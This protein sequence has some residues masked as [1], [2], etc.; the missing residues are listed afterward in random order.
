MGPFNLPVVPQ[1]APV[2]MLAVDKQILVT[3]EGGIP[4][5]NEASDRSSILPGA[6]KPRSVLGPHPYPRHSICCH[7]T[8]HASSWT[9]VS[10]LSSSP[11]LSP[12][13]VLSFFLLRACV[14]VRSLGPWLTLKGVGGAVARLPARA[15]AS[16]TGGTGRAYVG[17][18]LVG[19]SWHGGPRTRPWYQQ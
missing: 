2:Q 11:L 16:A 3:V 13:L 6:P 18:E 8:I 4:G 7:S 1:P 12:H 5:S 15:N 14:Q 19:C 17:R 9:P 10:L